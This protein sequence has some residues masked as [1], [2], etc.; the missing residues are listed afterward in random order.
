MNAMDAVRTTGEVVP[1]G[2][3]LVPRSP[4]MTGT[5]NGGAGVLAG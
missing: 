3:L 1:Y 2:E 4:V 5:G